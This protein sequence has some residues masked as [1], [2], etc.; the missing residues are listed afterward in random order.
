MRKSGPSQ[1]LEAARDSRSLKELMALFD[2]S[3]RT[4]FR[5]HVVNP[6]PEAGFLEMTV[7]DRPRSRLQSYRVT[8]TRPRLAGTPPEGEIT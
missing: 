2:R 3:N 4:V 1:L 5:D 6:L 8:P 7:P